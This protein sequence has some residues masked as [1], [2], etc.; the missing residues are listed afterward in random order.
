M[1]EFFPHALALDF[2]I[3]LTPMLPIEAVVVGTV[4][5]QLLKNHSKPQYLRQKL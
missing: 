4:Q 1:T 2:V 3:S 5:S